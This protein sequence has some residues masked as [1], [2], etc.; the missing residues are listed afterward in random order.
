MWATSPFAKVMRR[1]S[2]WF[3]V[4]TSPKASPN[5]ASMAA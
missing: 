4:A 2:V 3:V 1:P 5:S